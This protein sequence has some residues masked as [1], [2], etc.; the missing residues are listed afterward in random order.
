MSQRFCG[1]LAVIFI[2]WVIYHS[3]IIG[4]YSWKT[5]L[6]SITKILLWEK[7]MCP[8]DTLTAEYNM[9]QENYVFSYIKMAALGNPHSWCPTCISLYIVHLNEPESP[10]LPADSFLGDP[11]GLSPCQPGEFSRVQS[12]RS[13]SALARRTVDNG[14]NAHLLKGSS[15]SDPGDY[16][17]GP[18][19]RSHWPLPLLSS[20]LWSSV[21]LP[22]STSKQQLRVGAG[23][24][25]TSTWK[26]IYERTQE[27]RANCI[28]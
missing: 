11:P 14:I 8:I 16:L 28:S 25:K 15:K 17:D 5:W 1:N 18:P 19:S 22:G 6:G 9:W 24:P 20:W 2:A 7:K 26:L 3:N 23:Q 27:G 4:I 13:T 21:M 12:P 10:S